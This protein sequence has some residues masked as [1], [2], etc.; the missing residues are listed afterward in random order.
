MNYHDLYLAFL[1]DKLKLE[2][3][4]RVVLDASNGATHSLLEPLFTDPSAEFVNQHLINITADPDF[5]A[6]GPNPV[7]LGATDSA[8]QAMIEH[9]ADLGVIYDADGDRAVFLDSTGRKLPS[10]L[11][12]AI[13]AEDLNDEAKLVVDELVY[14]SL[15]QTKLLPPER[16]QPSR[17]GSYNIK[18]LMR[19]READLAA[20]LSGHYYFKDFFYADSALLATIRVLNALSRQPDL[21]TKHRQILDR[22]L[23]QEVNFKLKAKIDWSTL[24][25]LLQAESSRQ[26]VTNITERDGLTFNYPTGW[27]NLR[28]SN[29]EPLI[30]LTAHGPADWLKTQISAWQEFFDSL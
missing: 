7:A 25:P 29:T 4:L 1:K 23:L 14:Q 8:A 11:M 27:L 26:G 3:P 6:N 21:L 20:E 2:R 24:A 16:L 15:L 30:R 13:M 19:E 17:V 9:G 22:D 10:Y 5:K 28:P 18:Q 12:A